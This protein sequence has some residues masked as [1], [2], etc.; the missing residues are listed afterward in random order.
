MNYVFHELLGQFYELLSQHFAVLECIVCTVSMF[1][2]L[3]TKLS[4]ENILRF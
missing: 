1:N 4:K 3:E 2:M